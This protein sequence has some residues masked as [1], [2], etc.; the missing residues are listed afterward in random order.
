MADDFKRGSIGFVGV[1]KEATQGTPNWD[2]TATGTGTTTTTV[3]NSSPFTDIDDDFFNDDH[4]LYCYSGANAGEMKKITDW[5]KST[6]TFTHEAF[7]VATAS[8]D[9]FFVLAPIPA[10]SPEP[11]AGYVM[12]PRDAFHR[13]TLDPPSSL[14][15]L[16][17]ASIA[18]DCEVPA[19]ENPSTS[20]T[21]P[22]KD[23]FSALL[24]IIGSRTART[25][26]TLGADLAAGSTT[27]T[28]G[29]AH[30]YAVGD[31][32]MIDGQ[33]RHVETVPS[34][35][36]FTIEKGLSSL[37][38]SGSTIYTPEQWTPADTGHQA[39][40]V[41]CLMDD[42]LYSLE[43]CVG[44]VAGTWTF[45]KLQKFSFSFD[46]ESWEVEDSV[47]VTNIL[48]QSSELVVAFTTGCGHFGSTGLAINE[49]TFDLGHEREQHIDCEAG[50]RYFITTRKSTIGLKFRNKDKTPLTSWIANATQGRVVFQGGSAAGG[51]VALSANGQ[52]ESAGKD[53]QA[54]ILHYDAKLVCVDDQTSVAYSTKM[55]LLRF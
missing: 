21:A 40:T 9:R 1:C 26:N 23:R 52:L 48:A 8:G 27:V 25:G 19:L 49:A 46:G 13:Q 36:S 39:L 51:C 2:A 22:G 31:H 10:T 47:D 4:Y 53:V 6:T 32:V 44:S 12:L 55:C 42:Q 24:S 16:K 17:K 33:V 18:F 41:L 5:S 30:G 43:G 45:G 20:S 38:S 54:G 34:T 35:T 7:S 14:T 15:G 29:S 11:E 37:V 50:Q 28:T 3:V